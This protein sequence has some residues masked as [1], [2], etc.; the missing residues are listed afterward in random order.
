MAGAN[1]WEGL[2]DFDPTPERSPVKLDASVLGR[3]QDQSP[4]PSTAQSMAR[5]KSEPGEAKA[6][7]S[8]A[9]LHMTPG[10]IAQA[11]T[12]L[13]WKTIL[14]SVIEI[15]SVG[16]VGVCRVLQEVW[17]RGGGDTVSTCV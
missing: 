2:L 10:R 5:A 7:P 6:G 9:A 11:A 16:E 3:D 1:I 15:E 13:A 14:G 8:K 17:K 12:D 4:K